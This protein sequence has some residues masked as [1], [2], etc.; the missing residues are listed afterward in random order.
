MQAYH[1]IAGFSDIKSELRTKLGIKKSFTE[2]QLW[3]SLNDGVLY[4]HDYAD[5]NKNMVLAV[6]NPFRGGWKVFLQKGTFGEVLV[7][8][9]VEKYS[10]N[11]VLEEILNL[12]RSHGFFPSVNET[13]CKISSNPC[14]NSRGG[15]NLSSILPESRA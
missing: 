15:I 9:I 10:A 7:K 1:I 3:F 2:L 5:H 6:H 12:Y 13:S 4:T 14:N 11:E 8:H